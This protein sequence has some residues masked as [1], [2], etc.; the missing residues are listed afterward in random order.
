MK[1]FLKNILISTLIGFAIFVFFAVLNYLN[2]HEIDGNWLINGLIISASYTYPLYFLSA[3]AFDFAESLGRKYKLKKTVS[4]LIGFPFVIILSVVAIVLIQFVLAEVVFDRNITIFGKT[5]WERVKIPM[6][7]SIS[8]GGGF[9]LFYYFFE[10]QKSKSLAKSEKITAVTQKNKAL[11]SQI[12]SHFLFNSLNV[13]S[14]LVDENPDKAQDFI[15]DLSDVYR[16]VL[17]Q[18]DKNWVSLSEEIK[19]AENY[20]ELVKTRFENGLKINIQS[21][22]I[23]SQKIIAPLTLQLLLENCIKHNIISQ[24]S[25]LNISIYTENNILI[26]ENNLN[27]KKTF[28]ARKGTGLNLIKSKYEAI[29]QKLEIDDTNEKFTIKIPLLTQNQIKMTNQINFTNQELDEAKKE[30]RERN[31]FYGN[32]ISYI[33]L[34]MSFVVIN[35]ISGGYFWAI[36]PIIGWGIGV[37]FHGLGVFV[38]GKK[39]GDKSWEEKQA[40]KLLEKRKQKKTEN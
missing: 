13:L 5:F 22:L 18:K 10:L 23:E 4:V 40:V 32:L 19:F 16:Y 20:L 33:I 21:N 7:I 28:Q 36:W 39:F 30:I 26:V 25:P 38:F 11:K 17:E 8:V 27:P 24:H 14:G 12:G 35:L 2:G 6:W 31:E 15:A 3:Y 1:K 29:K 37:I 34:S 9:Y